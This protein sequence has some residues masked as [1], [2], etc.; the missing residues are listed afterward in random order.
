MQYDESYL[1]AIRQHLRT[2]KPKCDKPR[3]KC[4]K[5]LVAELAVDIRRLRGMGYTLKEISAELLTEFKVT[6][7]PTTISRSMP[8]E[9]DEER[10]NAAARRLLRR[11]G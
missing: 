4:G 3:K 5:T 11:R 10:R 7:S 8:P 6:L 2:L 9:T 1:T